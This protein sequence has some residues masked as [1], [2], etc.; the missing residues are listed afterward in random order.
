[1]NVS[2]IVYSLHLYLVLIEAKVVRVLPP[3]TLGKRCHIF[4]E[5]Q[6]SNTSFSFAH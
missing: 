2:T 1:M 3:K 4:T 6:N 5:M